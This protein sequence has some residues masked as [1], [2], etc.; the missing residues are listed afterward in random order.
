MAVADANTT[1][2]IC[3]CSGGANYCVNNSTWTLR[4][5]GDVQ[6]NHS[7]RTYTIVGS[8][9]QN[10]SGVS[11]YTVRMINATLNGANYGNINP[12]WVSGMTTYLTRTIATG[13][14]DNNGNPSQRN[15]SF[16][17]Y[18]C[19]HLYSNACTQAAGWS[20]CQTTPHVTVSVPNIAALNRKPG[21]NSGNITLTNPDVYKIETSIRNIDWGLNYSNPVLTCRVSYTLDGTNYNYELGRWTGTATSQSASVDG[22][23]TNPDT[24]W[25]KVPEDNDLTITWTASTS[26]GS[27]SVSKT[28]KCQSQYEAFVIGPSTNYETVEADLLVSDMEGKIPNKGIRRISQL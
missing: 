25:I 17:G 28:I 13:S 9:A 6:I 10:F 12:G 1:C 21:F 8:L 11:S 3:Y 20:G 15:Y 19:I 7:A 5:I 27:T 18:A 26:V 16:N 24:P 23:I 2:R 14:F 4:V 22:F